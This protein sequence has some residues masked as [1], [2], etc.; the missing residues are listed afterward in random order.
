MS[1]RESLSFVGRA[2]EAE[3]PF[4]VIVIINE[5]RRRE[6]EQDCK[7]A[8]PAP[9]V[10]SLCLSASGPSA[11]PSVVGDNSNGRSV[12]VV[13]VLVR[14]RTRFVEA[15]ERASEQR[16]NEEQREVRRR[17]RRRRLNGDGDG[18]LL[19]GGGEMSGVTRRRRFLNNTRHFVNLC[20][21][22]SLI[23][24]FKNRIFLASVTAPSPHR[25]K[26]EPFIPGHCRAVGLGLGHV[27][28]DTP[29]TW[30]SLV[31]PSF[32]PP[33]P[34]TPSVS[35]CDVIPPRGQ[36]PFGHTLDLM[37]LPAARALSNSLSLSFFRS[38]VVRFSVALRQSPP[39]SSLLPLILPL[40][41][42]IR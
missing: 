10:L 33:F 13:V 27:I 24:Q 30:A 32:R 42:S 7:R 15:R 23:S 20:P 6:G 37:P 41:L 9:V 16:R 25:I 22:A 5:E 29:V 34:E 38:F 21:F 14:A 3:K 4:S 26:I 2:T 17:R 39:S 11:R 1:E 28:H 18:G 19:R 31:F 12:V 36:L 35:L 40:S 8:L